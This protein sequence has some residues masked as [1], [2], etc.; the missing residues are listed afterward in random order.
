MKIKQ[1]NRQTKF[2][3]CRLLGVSA[4][5][6]RRNARRVCQNLAHRHRWVQQATKIAFQ[7]WS[8]DSPYIMVLQQQFTDSLSKRWRAVLATQEPWIVVLALE[9]SRNTS[10]PR[11]DQTDMYVMMVLI[12]CLTKVSPNTCSCCVDSVEQQMFFFS[13][14]YLLPSTLREWTC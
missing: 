13:S 5:N 1:A 2:S 10:W 4:N 11:W 14:K 8:H 6:N 7:G 3:G 12:A 9:G